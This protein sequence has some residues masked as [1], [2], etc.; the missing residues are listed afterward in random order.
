MPAMF[1]LLVLPQWSCISLQ[2]LVMRP[3][4]G[5]TERQPDANSADRQ[6]SEKEPQVFDSSNLGEH[7]KHDYNEELASRN[8]HKLSPMTGRVGHFQLLIFSAHRSR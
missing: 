3:S 8:G 7:D 2:A 5:L 4:T 6:G 1:E